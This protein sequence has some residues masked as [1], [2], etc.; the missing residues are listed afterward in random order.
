[1]NAGLLDR[2]GTL[3]ALAV[4]LDTEL[5]LNRGGDHGGGDGAEELALLADLD[6]DGHVLALEGSL[7]GLGVSD[8]LLLALGDV[9]AT[10][11]ELL[12]VARGG[13][14]GHALGEQEVLRVALSDVDDVTLAT[15]APELTQKDDFHGHSFGC[16][17][18]LPDDFLLFTR[19][20]PGTSPH[21]V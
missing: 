10:L 20:V 13:G 14:D 5:I 2:G 6:I 21:H 7:H 1:M 18:G 11:L 4:N 9:V 17:S 16:S 15:L 3:D 19:P 12:D 8:T